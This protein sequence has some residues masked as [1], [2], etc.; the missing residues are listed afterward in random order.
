MSED[1]TSFQQT[2]T[3]TSHWIIS[4]ITIV[5]SIIFL[6]SFQKSRKKTSSLYMILILS[7]ADLCFPI[8]NVAVLLFMRSQSTATLF[9]VLES[10]LYRFSLYWS[11]AFS[12]LTFLI[13]SKGVSF[14]TSTFMKSAFVLAFGLAFICPYMIATQAFGLNVIYLG[15]GAY[16]FKFTDPENSN[17]T[18]FYLLYDILLTLLPVLI[19]VYC[20][21][22]VYKTLKSLY[23]FAIDP[24]Q[25]DPRK[26]LLYTLIPIL[27][28]VPGNI[29]NLVYLLPGDIYPFAVSY[30]IS[31]TKRSW[32]FLN[33]LAYWY[34]NF[35]DER[36]DIE[37]S[38]TT[39]DLAF[40]TKIN[41]FSESRQS[42]SDL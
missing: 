17:Q 31:V 33:L 1:R 42:L 15:P 11:T 19:I 9:F 10:F 28:F 20:Y 27:T 37:A 14:S 4:T 25:L 32:G 23:K 5:A 39:S 35:N 16:A 41:P 18:A 7:I 26:V 6:R 12:I 38:E 21:Y 22:Q 2:L 24:S 36:I 30:F 8:V 29:A 34:L 13:L 40:S 3:E